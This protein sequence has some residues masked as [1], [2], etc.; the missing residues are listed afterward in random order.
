MIQTQDILIMRLFPKPQDQGSRPTC[1]VY[2]IFIR[3]NT[4]L[5]TGFLLQSDG[6]VC[7]HLTGPRDTRGN[8]KTGGGR[9]LIVNCPVA[10]VETFTALK[11]V[12]E[13]AN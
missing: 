9:E 1:H 12:P 7:S 11:T 10:V 6:W 2:L 3:C 4:E 13:N 5:S 8:R